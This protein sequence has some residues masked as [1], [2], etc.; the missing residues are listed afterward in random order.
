MKKATT[1]VIPPNDP[2]AV[3]IWLT[4]KAMGLPIVRSGQAHGA[5][6]DK[7]KRLLEKL[8]KEGAERVVVVEM[9]GP[10]MEEK[11]RNAGYEL[12]LIDHHEYAGLDRARHPK[13]GRMLPSSL[14]QFVKLFKLTDA[15]LAAL[16]FDPKLVRGIGIMDRGFVWE[17]REEGWSWK[18]IGKLI[19]YQESLMAHVRNRAHEEQKMNVVRKIWEG[20]KPWNGFFIVEGDT[21]MSVRVRISLIAALDRKKPTP[22]IVNEKGRGFIYVQDS[23]V[24]PLLFRTFGGF[25]FGQKRNWGYRN[26]GAKKKVTLAMVQEVLA[27]S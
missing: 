5:S 6:L 21:D 10:A 14:E 18:D 12:V 8:A 7:E 23:D 26:A 2:E 9:P 16:G 22:L 20:R 4:A 15:K 24:G 17:L 19:G 27:V 25:T 3:Q 13:T 1:L 11:L